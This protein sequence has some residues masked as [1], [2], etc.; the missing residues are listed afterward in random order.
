MG[1]ATEATNNNNTIAT[2]PSATKTSHT[3]TTSTSSTTT[4]STIINSSSGSFRGPSPRSGNNSPGSPRHAPVSPRHTPIN[5]SNSSSG[6]IT[7]SNSSSSSSLGNSGGRSFRGPSPSSSSSSISSLSSSIDNQQ[8]VLLVHVC[9]YEKEQLIQSLNATNTCVTI[10]NTRYR[11][12]FTDVPP[13]NEDPNSRLPR[14]FCRLQC[15]N[16][17]TKHGMDIYKTAVTQYNTMLD[18][19]AVDNNYYK[20]TH[21]P[22]PSIFVG[23]NIGNGSSHINDMRTIQTRSLLVEWPKNSKE[24]IYHVVGYVNS[25]KIHMV[26]RHACSTDDVDAMDEVIS[27]KAFTLEQLSNLYNAGNG[28]LLD[29]LLDQTNSNQLSVSGTMALLGVLTID[30]K[31]NLSQ[32]LRL[33]KASLRRFPLSLTMMG[34]HVTLLDFS[35]NKIRELPPEI[36]NLKYL[37]TLLLRNN[38]LDTVPLEIAY[39]VG[40]RTINL[41]GNPMREFPMEIIEEGAERIKEFCLNII[42]RRNVETW[43]KVR[44]M[45]VGQE[46]VG[47]T[48]LLQALTR[49][50]KNKSE[51][52]VSGDTISTEGV[53]IQTVKNKSSSIEFSAW[54]FGGQQVFYPTHQ[55]FLTSRALYMLVFNVSDPDWAERVDYWVRQIKYI[56]EGDRPLIFFIGTHID[57]C[58]TPQLEMAKQV[59]NKTFATNSRVASPVHFVC[60]NT[61]VGIKDLN[62]RL[63]VEAKK[64]GL[65]VKNI[66]GT[67]LLLERRLSKRGTAGRPNTLLPDI[68]RMSMRTSGN[69]MGEPSTSTTPSPQQLDRYIN[70]F[71]YHN[72]AKLALVAPEDLGA[73]TDFLTNLGI[74]LHYNTPSLRDL[75]VLD[76]QWLADVMSSLVTFSHQWIKEGVLRHNDLPA[77]WSAYDPALRPTLLKILERF[78][79]SYQLDVDRSLV[80]SLLPEEPKGKVEAVLNREWMPMAEL[81]EA[82]LPVRF[83]GCDFNFEFMPLGFFGR[84]LLRV[85]HISGVHAKTYWRNGMLL[86]IDNSYQKQ[87]A[88]IT[89]SKRR[90]FNTEDAYKLSIEIRMYSGGSTDLEQSYTAVAFLRQIVFTVESLLENFYKSIKTKRVIPCS[91]CIHCRP[92]EEPHYYELSSC[93]AAIQDNNNTNKFVYCR[94]DPN[95]P[96][97][98]EKV[99]PDLVISK[100][101]TMTMADVE[102][103]SSPIGKGGFGLVYKGKLLRTGEQIAVKSSIVSPDQSNEET[104]QKFREF[105]REVFIMS[106]LSH[107]N[108]VRLHGYMFN[109]PRIVMEFVPKGDLYHYLKDNK[110]A[111][112]TIPWTL[113]TRMMLDL[114]NGLHY[115]QSLTPPVI[116]RDLRSPNIFLSSLDEDAPVVV[117]I[118]DFGLSQQSIHSVA[119]ILLSYQ[120]MAPEAISSQTEGYTEKAD[121]YS[122]AMILYEILSGLAPFDEYAET[123]KKFQVIDAIRTKHLRPTLP[124]TVPA[125]LRNV[126]ELCWSGEPS[127]RPEFPYIIKELEELRAGIETVNAPPAPVSVDLNKRSWRATHKPIL[128]P[129]SMRQEQFCSWHRNNNPSV[130]VNSSPD[131][132]K[133]M[134]M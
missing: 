37:D 48:S 91:H 55:F 12:I 85:L 133:M 59:I 16:T 17:K 62:K 125:K 61:G 49:V 64:C 114:A 90:K 51:L 1:L 74:I 21:V 108:I 77:V 65:I 42:E 86:D 8:D 31:G 92:R 15:F 103:D 132:T 11:V 67:Y 70:I 40:L 109:P 53:K 116:H 26:L 35:D 119:G 127:S 5:N 79:V 44:L 9:G 14:T 129:W 89:F 104:V 80:P 4:S 13:N 63:A 57:K 47:K 110:A 99:A 29:S 72:E 88:L 50:K 134:F 82:R 20:T 30:K 98:L 22:I 81:V 23:V 2:S 113:Q 106:S 52:Q 115:M 73:A 28:M 27:T 19:F 46:G 33:S 78:E 130:N 94:N 124:S 118:A 43:N 39:L 25:T 95:E 101:P 3:P 10:I 131:T 122:F 71:D 112:M 45:F 38:L 123:M 69:N 18:H 6:S 24:L 32:T 41:Q 36:M 121:T 66:P 54:D 100:V 56:C 117:K 128:H 68:A 34:L 97:A 126:I 60:C 75:V 93:V 105:Q 107:P 102:C 96:V 7:S 111:G 76:P 58:T 87:Q 120:W 84:L 83:Y